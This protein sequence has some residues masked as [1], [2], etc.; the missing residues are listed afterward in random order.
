MDKL[1]CPECNAYLMAGDGQCHDCSCGWK[2]YKP[3]M[4]RYSVLITVDASI[5]VEVEATD[6]ESAKEEAFSQASNPSVCHHCAKQVQL[7]DL[8]EA[9]EVTEVG[10]E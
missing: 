8:L 4:R 6:E 3:A 2:Q 7:G 5:V 9:V 10:N 1:Y